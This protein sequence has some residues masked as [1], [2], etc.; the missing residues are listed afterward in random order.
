MVDWM[1]AL[2]GMPMS[3]SPIAVV[4]LACGASN[5]Y[6]TAECGGCR[7]EL[8]AFPPYL[9]SNHVCQLQLDLAAYQEGG[10][11]REALLTSYATFAE[12]AMQEHEWPLELVSARASLHAALEHLDRWAEEGRDEELEPVDELLTDFFQYAC[13]GCAELL[14]A[15]EESA[16]TPQPLVDTVE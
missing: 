1:A 10:A 2:L 13:G 16:P 5:G 14:H 12:L 11:P 9:H 6:Q 3:D 4:C 7:R 8:A 15:Q